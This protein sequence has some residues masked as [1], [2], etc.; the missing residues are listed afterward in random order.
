M[1]HGTLP[2]PL[3]PHRQPL[4]SFGS[5][6]VALFSNSCTQ[7]MFPYLFANVWNYTDEAKLR[8]SK[9]GLKFHRVVDAREVAVEGN[10]LRKQISMEK[11]A[12]IILGVDGVKKP[13]RIAHSAGILIGFLQ[14][15]S[16]ML[17]SMLM[18][19]SNWGRH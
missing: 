2:L 5:D 10:E 14:S 13:K 12:K 16:S 4:S 15:K 8:R 7:T 3:S 19:A 17:V 1:F 6:T 9:H 11:L 18:L